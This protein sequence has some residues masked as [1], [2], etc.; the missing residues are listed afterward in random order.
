MESVTMCVP[1]KNLPFSKSIQACSQMPG[2]AA[3]SC[4]EVKALALVFWSPDFCV[5]S[6]SVSEIIWTLRWQEKGEGLLTWPLTVP[7]R[8]PAGW[9]NFTFDLP[10]QRESI[11]GSLDLLSCQDIRFRSLDN[12][13][14]IWESHNW[15]QITRHSVKT[16]LFYICLLGTLVCNNR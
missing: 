4:W 5:W 6:L 11:F 3:T 8:E 12:S 7:A 2:F 10:D 9:L 16:W 13:N 1:I 14:R 15:A